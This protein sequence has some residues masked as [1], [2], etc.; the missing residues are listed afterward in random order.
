MDM[1]GIS[2]LGLHRL[3]TLLTI[4]LSTW[5]KCSRLPRHAATSITAVAVSGVHLDG[6]VQ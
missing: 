4:G 6:T 1:R 2:A 5:V 3:M